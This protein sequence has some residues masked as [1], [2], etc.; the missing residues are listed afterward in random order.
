MEDLINRL[1]NFVGEF[2]K[3]GS[4]I[5][6]YLTKYNFYKCFELQFLDNDYLNSIII[7]RIVD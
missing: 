5:F 1:Y 6:V 2:G 3:P 7:L 4:P